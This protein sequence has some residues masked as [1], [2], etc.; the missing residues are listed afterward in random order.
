MDAGDIAI[1][2]A[3]EDRCIAVSDYVLISPNIE[4][5]SI[6]IAWSQS[7]GPAISLEQATTPSLTIE[8]NTLSEGETYGFTCSVSKNRKSV[9]LTIFF[10]VNQGPAGG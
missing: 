7:E 6:T 1:T 2:Y 4:G 8:P 10:T 9:S 3:V 5:D